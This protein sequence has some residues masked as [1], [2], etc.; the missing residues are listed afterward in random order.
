[1][2]DPKQVELFGRIAVHLKLITMDQLAEAVRG[3]AVEG[4]QLGAVLIKKGFLTQD[5][6]QKILQAQKAYLAKQGA[7][8]KVGASTAPVPPATPAEIASSTFFVA[9]CFAR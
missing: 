5:G 1:V 6:L 8:K 7:A 4:E 3:Q 2:G 9:P